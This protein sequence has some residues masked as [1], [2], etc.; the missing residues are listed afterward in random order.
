VRGCH[1]LPEIPKKTPAIATNKIF[2]RDGCL[3]MTVHN[4]H[5]RSW[6]TLITVHTFMFR[7]A[8]LTR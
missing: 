1:R 4:D 2:R 3:I 5:R 7:P 8:K 6:A